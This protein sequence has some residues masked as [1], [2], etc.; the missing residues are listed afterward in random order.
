[1]SDLK[2]TKE[3]NGSKEDKRLKVFGDFEIKNST[4]LVN[5]Q[6][7]DMKIKSE[8]QD[9]ELTV[10]QYFGYAFEWE[11]WK[12]FNELKPDK[13]C[14]PDFEEP[15][16]FDLSYYKEAAAMKGDDW[17]IVSKSKTK[18]MDVVA[19]FGKHAFV[20]ECKYTHEKKSSEKLG[21]AI[22]ELRIRSN[23]I[24]KRLNDLFD[25][26]VPVYILCTKNYDLDNKDQIE[27]LKDNDIIM[28]S[29]KERAYIT[30]VLKGER[31]K[32][33]NRYEGGSGS[34][35]FTLQ[36]FLGFFRGDKP[37][38]N[39]KGNKKWSIPAFHSLSG[40]N[41]KDRVFTFSINPN[42]M[43]K[44]S[45]VAH[46]KLKNAF[47]VTNTSNRYYQRVL[48]K[49]RL[50]S[51]GIHLN[52]S[53]QP[54]PNNILVSY[55]GGSKLNFIPDSEQDSNKGNIPGIMEF[56]ACP[57]TFHVIDGQHR[58]FGYTALPKKQGIRK[59]HRLIVTAFDGLTV[60]EEAEIFLEV[61]S[62]AEPIG[63]DLLIEIEWASEAETPKNIRNGVVL[64][65]R[66]N[67]KSCLHNMILQAESQAKGKLNLPNLRNNLATKMFTNKSCEDCFFWNTDLKTT[68]ADA[69]EFINVA[70]QHFQKNNIDR[71]HKAEGVLQDIFVGGLINLIDRSI[72]AL[73][74]KDIQE[75]SN[76]VNAIL[77]EVGEKFSKETEERKKE[78]LNM[79]AF[80]GL[81]A[82]APEKVAGWLVDVYLK[83]HSLYGSLVD[84]KDEI[85]LVGVGVGDV[86]KELLRTQ[87]ELQKSQMKISRL[88]QEKAL[89]GKTINQ[90]ATAYFGIMKDIM[91][92]VLSK[93]KHYSDPHQIWDR[94]IMPAFWNEGNVWDQILKRVNKERSSAGSNR[95]VFE[96]N[97]VEG[98][99]LRQLM[100][101]FKKYRN[102]K[103]DD[104]E[105]GLS[106]EERKENLLKYIWENL[107]IPPEG[108]KFPK[109]VTYDPIFWESGT[110]YYK[111]FEACR[112]YGDKKPGS[113]HKKLRK[114]PN[115]PIKEQREKFEYY[116]QQFK[117]LLTKVKKDMDEELELDI[118]SLI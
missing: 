42:D 101:D 21:D 11:M 82:K 74:G 28:L 99:P 53:K 84:D 48:S 46:Q 80:F 97:H 12:F 85:N 9:E 96:F 35:E 78:V 36:Q 47:E 15:F 100:R 91:F 57:G 93:E 30:T 56:D 40:P 106:A 71:W 72:S 1:M 19:I 27:S 94:V 89:E 17:G 14:D 67:D 39:E 61:N 59:D 65:L 16:R 13:I 70:L 23:F 118:D 110:E 8:K 24:T 4:K 114:E 112:N 41:K 34:P 62:K 32:K 5:F 66:D 29:E 76:E 3:F 10:P 6:L 113:P 20:I 98:D 102:V 44:I 33:T 95:F 79:S 86:A 107:L 88:E 31:N 116:E 58:L 81:G 49:K 64:N 7:R 105:G 63:T 73:D 51:L 55:R 37:D 104:G 77:E 92:E 109:N 68:V 25:G 54:Y 52:S 87:K 115:D 22:D 108:E 111:I 103:V 117:L 26:I 90:R 45:T 2:E 60:E 75:I 69:Y 83:K 38:Y 50:S 18:Q 43:L